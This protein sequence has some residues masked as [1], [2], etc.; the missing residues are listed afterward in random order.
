MSESRSISAA[1]SVLII[2][3]LVMLGALYAQVPP[4]PPATI[5][6]FAIAPF[7]AVAL[8]TAAAALIIGPLASRTG[9]VLSLLAA[10]MAMLSFGPQKYLDL[11]FPL[12]WPAV[13]T[14]QVAVIA[15][16]IGVLIRQGHRSA[17]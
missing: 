9:K 16:F 2:L 15:I 6:L 10:L 5:P 17:R 4:H 8:A 12:I 13:L 1:L 14:A 11:Q 3:Q 7:L